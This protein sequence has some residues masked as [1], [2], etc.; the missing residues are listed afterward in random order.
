MEPGADGVAKYRYE[1]DY[2]P[3]NYVDPDHK[4]L[5]GLFSLWR[6][7]KMLYEGGIGVQPA[8]YI[9]VMMM[10]DGL[11]AQAEKAAIEKVGKS[12]GAGIPKAPRRR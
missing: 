11:W 5:L 9:D 2:C 3:V 4:D 8:K 6:S 7:G 12:K 10:L 1:F